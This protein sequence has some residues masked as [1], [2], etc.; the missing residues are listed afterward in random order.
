MDGYKDF[1]TDPHRYPLD[2]FKKFID[3]I[4]GTDQHYIPMFDAG[5]YVPNPNNASDIYEI[6]HNG[7]ESDSFLKNPD[8][9][10][11][12]G[13]V[14]PGFTAFPDFLAPKSQEF[15]TKTNKRLLR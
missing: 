8:G 13:S 12:I 15:W 14:W 6:F 3:D 9:S 11:Y 5:I 7:N 2:K 10:L 4:H 1:T